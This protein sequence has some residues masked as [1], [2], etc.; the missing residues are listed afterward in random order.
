M[1][2]MKK[3]AMHALFTGVL[4]VLLM[5]VLLMMNYVH[6]L[7]MI[8]GNHVTFLSLIS[9]MTVETHMIKCKP[10]KTWN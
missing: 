1:L 9:H 2:E 10:F 4:G 7:H 3:E 8:M 6:H 5:L